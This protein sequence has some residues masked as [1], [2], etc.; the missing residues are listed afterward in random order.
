[1]STAGADHVIFSKKLLVSICSLHFASPNA[2]V[3]FLSYLEWCFSG[4]NSLG[5][6]GTLL[7]ANQP[8][9]KTM[10]L[11][12]P[13]SSWRRPSWTCR[14]KR[15]STHLHVLSYGTRLVNMYSQWLDNESKDLQLSQEQLTQL[16]SKFKSVQEK[17]VENSKSLS[18]KESSL[19]EQEQRLS[20]ALHYNV[21]LLGI[22]IQDP[23]EAKLY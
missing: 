7:Q 22:P 15:M 13:M 10:L 8:F 4:L 14:P 11:S 2:Q 3:Q 18:Q 21:L 19:N 17:I 12:L 16:K 1:V 6:L 20:V 9:S 5:L 23:A